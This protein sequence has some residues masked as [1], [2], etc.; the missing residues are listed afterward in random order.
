MS[1]KNHL[2]NL[3][4]KERVFRTGMVVEAAMKK[5]MS[6]RSA[7]YFIKELVDNGLI[8]PVHRGVYY[9]KHPDKPVSRS[10]IAVIISPKAVVSLDTACISDRSDPNTIFHLVADEGR[11]GSFE[12]PLGPIAIHGIPK[13]LM[14]DL[15]AKIGASEMY[16][17]Q[18][19]YGPVKV[20]SREVS[21]IHIAYLNN[22]RKRG[23]TYGHDIPLNVRSIVDS[24]RLEKLSAEL[25]VP[26]ESFNKISP[27]TSPE[28]SESPT[29]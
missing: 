24:E 9:I 21:I 26:V 1:L 6:K 2:S 7:D 17:G 19:G 18:D 23:K 12:S 5:G 15:E 25:N 4:S 3:I 8:A 20:V 27:A 16:Q 11:I 29:I 28:T 10:E 22:E 13:A 14:S